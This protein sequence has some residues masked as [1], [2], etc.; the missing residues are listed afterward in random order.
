MAFLKTLFKSHG[1]PRNPALNRAMDTV[2]KSDNQETREALYKIIL[3]STF[4]L[5]RNGSGDAQ[6][7]PGNRTAD[8]NTRVA[9]HTVEHPPGH[10]VL[11]VFTD[12]DALVAWSGAEVQWIGLPARTLFESILPTQID[13]VRINPFCKEQ[14]PSRTGGIV[15]RNEFVALAQGLLPQSRISDN[16]MEMKLTSGQQVLIGKP[17]NQLPAELLGR[18][19]EHLR[20]IPEL[21]SAYLFQMANQRMSSTV[22]GLH[23]A[24]QPSPQRMAQVMQGIAEIVRGA[25]P[26][27]AS[28]DFMPLQVGTFLDSIQKSGIALLQN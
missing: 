4:I 1:S 15:T 8:N 2:A 5:P 23:F 21:R 27:G 19:I 20:Q 12:V 10:I 6:I 13:E 24:V 9:F 11:P 7:K 3:A 18:L 25:I 14:A 16:A 17:A 22:V 26:S 28:I